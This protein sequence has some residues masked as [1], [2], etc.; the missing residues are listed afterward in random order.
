MFI[1]LTY[2]VIPLRQ[3]AECSEHTKAH[4]APPE[5][6]VISA[7]RGYKHCAPPEHCIPTVDKL[8]GITNPGLKLANAFG[9]TCYSER[10][11]SASFFVRLRLGF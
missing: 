1:A 9:V 11:F 10:L 8:F 2:R 6:G 3:G 5:R 7:M 4:C